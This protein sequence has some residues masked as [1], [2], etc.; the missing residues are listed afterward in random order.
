V[1][2]SAKAGTTS[3]GTGVVST[4]VAVTGVGFQPKAIIFFWSNATS[5]NATANGT[6]GRGIGFATSP[7][8]RRYVDALSHHNQAAANEGV[9]YRDD[10]CVVLMNTSAGTPTAGRLDLQ[11]MDS[12]GFTL[13]VDEQ[14][15]TNV[16]FS[17]IALGGTTVTNAVTFAIQEPG[18]TGSQ[19]I[20]GIGFRPDVLLFAA[21]GGTTTPPAWV[22]HSVMSF[23]FANGTTSA[24]LGDAGQDTADPTVQTSYIKSGECI[25]LHNAAATATDARAS[26]ASL[27]SDGFTL[28]WA[29]RASTR[30]IFG[31]AIK[32]PQSYIGSLVASTTPTTT[33]AQSGF[34][35]TPKAILGMANRNAE[36]TSDTTVKA[37]RA[38]CVGGCTEIAA[39]SRHGH[40]SLARDAVGTSSCAKG[41]RTDAWIYTDFPGTGTLGQIDIDTIDADGFTVI[42]DDADTAMFIPYLAL[43][44]AALAVTPVA[45][46]AVYT[47]VA[48]SITTGTTLTPAA[49]VAT[50]TV[51]AATGT[52]NTTLAPDA[53][54]AVYGVPDVAVVSDRGPRIVIEYWRDSDSTWRPWGTYPDGTGG[55]ILPLGTPG[56]ILGPGLLAIESDALGVR[57]CRAS[58]IGGDGVTDYKIGSFAVMGLGNSVFRPPTDTIPP[59]NPS[60]LLADWDPG[61]SIPFTQVL[62][63]RTGNYDMTL[64]G[65]SAAEVVD[66]NWSTPGYLTHTFKGA[67]NWTYTRRSPFVQLQSSAAIGVFRFRNP[68]IA[69]IGNLFLFGHTGL[70]GGFSAH[71]RDCYTHASDWLIRVHIGGTVP[72]IV[73]STTAITAGATLTIGYSHDHVAETLTIY[74][75]GIA[76]NTVACPGT[77]HQYDATPRFL[78]GRTHETIEFGVKGVKIGRFLHYSGPVT[79]AAMLDLHNMLT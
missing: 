14:F 3:S 61:E 73:T 20:T 29:E 35:F 13:V 37:D 27:D 16:V 1:A 25:A 7:T 26:L 8:D 77:G 76:E 70:V 39:N 53:A 33:Q 57:I 63:D 10:C 58:T 54:V 65:T 21:T 11:S 40:G 67:N 41:M 69:D 50:Y 38:W 15:T 28:S 47:A 66:P 6:I 51:P 31:L 22:D 34:G 71:D 5:T 24:V 78:L 79:A 72:T 68:L 18:A 2:L 17:W 23:G 46:E 32:G 42:I 52:T 62:V 36:S 45:A 9:S 59:A 74:I 60:N 75:N 64:G 48:P 56:T 12:D 44:D 19:A 49:A 55:P 4:T 30:W 43:G